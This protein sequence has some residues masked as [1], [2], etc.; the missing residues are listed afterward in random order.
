MTLFS[1]PQYVLVH[2]PEIC[3][4]RHPCMY[5][6]PHCICACAGH[7]CLI[8]AA[9]AAAAAGPKPPR[10]RSLGSRSWRRASGNARR[11]GDMG[12]CDT[13]T[14]PL[15]GSKRSRR[16]SLAGRTDIH[17]H[18]Q[19]AVNHWH[20]HSRVRHRQ[21]H[22]AHNRCATVTVTVTEACLWC[23][24]KGAHNACTRIYTCTH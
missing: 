4:N 20:A 1:L 13:R 12:A 18:A 6:T 21:A 8:A 16:S 3:T 15:S 2:V 19:E 17:G 14:R 5:R 7:P 11:G 9:E 23:T 24:Q 22:N 10:K